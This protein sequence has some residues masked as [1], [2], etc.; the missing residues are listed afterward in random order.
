VARRATKGSGLE[1][2]LLLAFLAVVFFV[3]P[4]VLTLAVYGGLFC[5]FIGLLL[6]ELNARAAPAVKSA[7][8]FS[9]P[10]EE[11]ALDSLRAH[12]EQLYRR[13]A[14]LYAEGDGLA[15]T[16]RSHD[17]TRYDER[18]TQAKR[19]NAKLSKLDGEYADIDLQARTLK[20]TVQERYGLWLAH[21]ERWRFYSSG[22]IAFRIA[23]IGFLIIAL[24][25]I[26]FKPMWS[27]Q[28]SM[29]VADHVWFRTPFF[30]DAYGA[31]VVASGI[32]AAIIPLI[33]FVACQS[34]VVDLPGRSQFLERWMQDGAERSVD[35]F[36]ASYWTTEE[37]E[38][39]EDEEQHE[40]GNNQA[41]RDGRY[42]KRLSCYEVLGVDRSASTEDIKAAYRD[43]IKQYHPDR[44]AS[45]G[46]ELRE[47]A[48]RKT[49]ALNA[50]YE[51]A[52]GRA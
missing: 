43:K 41:E 8:E 3:V 21:F 14:Q 19:L 25:L 12:Q 32:S 34:V 50:A 1:G 45:L 5:I 49:K 31:L 39:Q 16:R 6:C 24:S 15:L 13:K 51:E 52:L 4:A 47:L 33:W 30:S 48:E 9:S 7:T 26:I 23:I 38:P 40:F 22:R 44:V 2:L 42:D 46:P 36:V 29:T 10:D 20:G 35:D 18:K 37:V 28:F 11:A 17:T 27:E